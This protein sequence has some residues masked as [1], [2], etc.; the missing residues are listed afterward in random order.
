MLPGGIETSVNSTIVTLDGPAI[1][2]VIIA[3]AWEWHVFLWN[4]AQIND[5]IH[6]TIGP[7]KRDDNSLSAMVQRNVAA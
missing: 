4:C 3:A 2:T 6:E 5:G 1:T 7:A